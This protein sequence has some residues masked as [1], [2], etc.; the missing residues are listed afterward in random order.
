M[1]TGPESDVV[2]VVAQV[3]RAL[4]ERGEQIGSAE[5]L[6]GGELAALLS[7]PPGASRTYAGG[8]VTYATELKRRLLGVT[9]KHVVSQECAAQMATG[10]RELLGVEWALAT[11]GVAGPERQEDQP[12]GTVWVAM[13]GPGVVRTRRLDLAGDRATV[14]AAACSSA[15]DLWL[16]EAVDG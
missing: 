3:H 8:V 5:S 16:A 12:A 7:A 11:T 6:T 15:L 1:S 14:R 4:R 10:A 9:A 13:A 2:R